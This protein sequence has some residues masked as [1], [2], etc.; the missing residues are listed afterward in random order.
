MTPFAGD[1]EHLVLLAV[2]RHAD[3][4]TARDVR[5]T[6]ARRAGRDAS[7]GALYATLHRMDEKGWIEWNPADSVPER[8]GIPARRVVLTAAGRA[9]ARSHHEAIHRLAEGTDLLQEPA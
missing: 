6:L 4:A 3:G 5:E 7:R 1:L 9:V 8:G 2:H